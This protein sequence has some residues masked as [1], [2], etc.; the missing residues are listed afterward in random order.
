[1]AIQTYS[2]KTLTKTSTTLH[3]LDAKVG[4]KESEKLTTQALRKLGLDWEE[5]EHYISMARTVEID[6]KYGRNY[7]F[8][9][10]AS[11]GFKRFLG[12][13]IQGKKG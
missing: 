1:M 7:K 11:L 2:K 8:M 12:G 6:Q 9:I 10:D 13:V 4:R 5:A 3:H